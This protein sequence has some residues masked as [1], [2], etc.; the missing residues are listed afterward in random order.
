[1]GKREFAI[2]GATGNIGSRLTELL[3]EQGH[4]VRTI[5]RGSERLQALVRKGADARAGSVDD[6]E[7]LT[8]AF[9]GADGVFVMVPPNLTADYLRDYSQAVSDA[10][11]AALKA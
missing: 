5:A 4:A 1:M 6:A 10:E 9:R 11:V 8:E 3:L 7:F 2:T